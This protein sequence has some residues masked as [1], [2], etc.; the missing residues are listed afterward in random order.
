MGA[1]G[2]A[3]TDERQGVLGYA[4][5]VV[6]SEDDEQATFEVGGAQ[7]E[8]VVAIAFGIGLGGIHVA[9]AVHDFI[10]APVD[11]RTSGYTA[12]EDIV[13]GKHEVGGHE[14]AV[15]PS[16]Y[17]QTVGVDIGQGAQEVNT[18]HLVAHFFGTELAEGDVFKITSAFIA[19]SVVEHEYHVAQLGHVEFPSAGHVVP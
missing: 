14:A 9:F 1:C 17:T 18:F 11:D 15:A 10:I 3:S 6:V 13:V 16:V 12:L 7:G 8:V 5:W 4:H 2:F 19:T